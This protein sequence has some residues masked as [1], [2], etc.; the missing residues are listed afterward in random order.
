[1]G[2]LSV[3]VQAQLL[4]FLDGKTF[5][6][7]G[8]TRVLSAD[9]RLIAATNVNLKAAVDAGTFRRDLFY[10]LSVVPLRVPPLKERRE[11]LSDLA[12]RILRELG[13]RSGGAD[14][15]LTKDAVRV[16]EEYDWPGNIRELRNTLERTIIMGAS[17]EIDAHDLPIELRERRASGKA[18]V[19][20]DTARP[21]EEL[22]REQ[23][24]RALKQTSGNRTKAAELLGISRAT[25]KR[26]L[27]DMRKAGVD[28]PPES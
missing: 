11:E 13:R 10:R 6:R 20:T 27:A 17:G 7:V 1:V 19:A 5:R 18:R 3:A 21:L 8:G 16:L 26:R 4:T 2:E 9:V 23:I 22:E 25:M 24:L 14:P 28:V 15:H 12:H